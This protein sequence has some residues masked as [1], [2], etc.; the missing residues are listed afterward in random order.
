MLGPAVCL[1]EAAARAGFSS[2]CNEPLLSCSAAFSFPTGRQ[3]TVSQGALDNAGVLSN[4]AK[5]L[6]CPAH[7]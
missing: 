2:R 4:H 6:F 7:P 1:Q 3:Q 5:Y